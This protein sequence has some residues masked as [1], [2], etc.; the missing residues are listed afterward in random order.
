MVS[1]VPSNTQSILGVFF[2]FWRTFYFPIP[3]RT[4]GGLPPRRG[5][6]PELTERSSEVDRVEQFPGEF[7]GQILTKFLPA[8]AVNEEIHRP[9]GILTTGG[10]ADVLRALANTSEASESTQILSKGPLSEASVRSSKID[11]SHWRR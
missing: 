5:G 7:D 6:G 2:W 11:E 10:R 4:G 3:N 8:E 1:G 9:G